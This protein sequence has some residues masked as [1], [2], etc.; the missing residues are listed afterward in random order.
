MQRLNEYEFIS[1]KQL[2]QLAASIKSIDSD[3][4]DSV[5]KLISNTETILEKLEPG[6]ELKGLFDTLKMVLRK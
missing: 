3:N 2:D 6:T 1:Q 5:A 4:N